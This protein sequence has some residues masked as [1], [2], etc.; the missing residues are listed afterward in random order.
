[1]GFLSGNAVF[2][3]PG[4]GGLLREFLLNRKD[5]ETQREVRRRSATMKIF[6]LRLSVLA[7]KK[8]YQ[9]PVQCF[10]EL[11]ILSINE[12]NTIHF[13]YAKPPHKLRQ[14]L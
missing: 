8:E 14:G 1:M 6:S 12:K 9:S 7:V 2:W 3:I 11:V 10:T 5:A 13:I 4:A